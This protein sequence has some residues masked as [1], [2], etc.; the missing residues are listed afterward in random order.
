M[1]DRITPAS[2]ALRGSRM[3]RIT[4]ALP[5][6]GGR[7]QDEMRDAQKPILGLVFTESG[8]IIGLLDYAERRANRQGKHVRNAR[9]CQEPSAVIGTVIRYSFLQ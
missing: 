9:E 6:S 7:G 8:P 2:L 4:P 3:R 5:F 1:G